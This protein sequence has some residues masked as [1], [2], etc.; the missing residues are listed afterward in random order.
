MA[1]I[2]VFVFY[3]N[4][5]FIFTASVLFVIF[6]GYFGIRQA[7]IFTYSNTL[8]LPETDEFSFKINIRLNKVN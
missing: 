2:W 7:G 3:G 1:I 4:D 6:I 5:N 8:T